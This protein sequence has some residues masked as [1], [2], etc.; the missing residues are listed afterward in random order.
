[1]CAKKARAISASDF[2]LGYCDKRLKVLI[3]LEF[4]KGSG[5]EGVPPKS[6]PVRYGG[7]QK[8]TVVSSGWEGQQA[9]RPDISWRQA[10][11]A[12]IV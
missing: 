2:E 1:M 11:G 5:N 4:E 9:V 3:S 10:L 6:G 8:A 7:S 12:W